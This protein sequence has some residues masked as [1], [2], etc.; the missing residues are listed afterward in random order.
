[1]L[2]VRP[3]TV[4]R[5]HRQ[6]CRLVWRQKSRAATPASRLPRETI[7]VIRQMGRDNPLRGADRIRGELL[8]LDLRVSKRTIQRYLR[9]ARPSRPP[10]QAWSSFVRNHAMETWACDFLPVTDLLFRPLYA[11]FSSSH[12]AHAAWCTS[13]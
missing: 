5:W 4:L 13:A 6:G 7:D 12:S 9:Q 11:F 2:I 10:G 3:E 1:M 8:K